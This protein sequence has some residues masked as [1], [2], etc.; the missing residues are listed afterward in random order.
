MEIYVALARAGLVAVPVNFRLMAPEIA[1]IAV[2][3]RGA[4]R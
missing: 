4:R 2:A 1:Y 3:L